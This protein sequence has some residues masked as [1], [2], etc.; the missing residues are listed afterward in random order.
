MKPTELQGG[1]TV[2]MNCGGATKGRYTYQGVVLC[3][4]CFSLAQHCDR[5][6][7]KEFEQLLAV[8]REGLRVALASGR[9][10]SGTPFAE[11]KKMTSTPPTFQEA[12]H[13]FQRLADTL[14]TVR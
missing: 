11:K 3:S 7:V 10:G 12:Q 2:C 1:I 13:F 4:H 14:K 9:L 6:A 8:Y 5:R